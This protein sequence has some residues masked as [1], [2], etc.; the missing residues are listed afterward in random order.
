[1][2]DLRHILPPGPTY[3]LSEVLPPLVL[4]SSVTFA[5]IKTFDQYSD[6]HVSGWLYLAAI[7]FIHPLARFFTLLRRRYAARRD[8]LDKGAIAPP[9]VEAKSRDIINTLTRTFATG[10]PGEAYWSWALR[11]GYVFAL[12]VFSEKRVQIF[13]MLQ[14]NFDYS[15]ASPDYNN[16]T[17]ACEGSPRDAV[18]R[19]REGPPSSFPMERPFGNGGLQCRWYVAHDSHCR[20]IELIY[21][22]QVTCGSTSV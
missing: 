13:C 6:S 22:L 15:F 11:Y 5:S 17:R 4:L 20:H 1:M 12:D 8:M 7:I 16:G 21:A 9:A 18:S 10:Y 2:Y 3:I 19:V 14:V